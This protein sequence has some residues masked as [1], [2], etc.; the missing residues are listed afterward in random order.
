M[1]SQ[2][3]NFSFFAAAYV[4]WNIVIHHKVVGFAAIE[5][6]VVFIVAL[7]PCVSEDRVFITGTVHVDVVKT[8]ILP[9]MPVAFI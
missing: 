3:R 4:L 7:V 6:Q 1:R 8:S 9:K 5:L 2:Y